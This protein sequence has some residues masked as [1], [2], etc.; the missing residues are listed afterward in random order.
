LAGGECHQ[1]PK[2]DDAPDHAAGILA[3]A[4]IMA[5]PQI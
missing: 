4:R 2:Q 3:L 1:Q 5:I